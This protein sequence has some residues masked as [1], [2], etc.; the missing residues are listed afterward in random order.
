MQSCGYC[1]QAAVWPLLRDVRP[2]FVRLAGAW[3]DGQGCGGNVRQLSNRL[4]KLEAAFP[5][6]SAD[7]F[8]E[9]L[10]FALRN[11]SG[12]DAGR[13]I[14]VALH[15][16][17]DADL[18]FLVDH[19]NSTDRGT[20]SAPAHRSTLCRLGEMVRA[21]VKEFGTAGF[22]GATTGGRA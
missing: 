22:V 12:D 20:P 3:R 13:A 19:L 15:K 21:A 4:K 10:D 18:R 5:A 1:K 2:T 9:A 7:P 11:L 6:V 17:S 8:G 14:D 16:A